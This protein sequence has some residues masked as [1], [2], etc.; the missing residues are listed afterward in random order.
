MQV[1]PM[2]QE[3]LKSIYR[4]AGPEGVSRPGDLADALSVSPATITARLKKLADQELVEHRPY[5][6]VTLTRKGR[7]AAIGAIRR[8]RIVERFLSDFLGYQWSEADQ[9]AVTFEHSLPAEVVQRM[10][11]ALDRPTACPHGFP[12]P[13]AEAEELAALATLADAD[14]GETIEVALPGDT[15]PDVVHFLDTI[16]IR[17]GTVLTVKERHPFE[18][19]VI[20]DVDGIDRVVGHK[21]AAEIYASAPK[22]KEKT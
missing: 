17:P 15:H 9:L 13:A 3:T 20:V 19:P 2:E 10:F 8:H 18:G 12:I 4:Q 1:S 21:L 11:N 5:Q 14:L 7:V 6:G 22:Q 16:G